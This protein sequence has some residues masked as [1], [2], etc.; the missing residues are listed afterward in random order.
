[1]HLLCV[2]PRGDSVPPGYLKI[3]FNSKVLLG[4]SP[5]LEASASANDGAGGGNSPAIG[6]RIRLE[7][8]VATAIFA[9]AS[10]A[11]AGGRRG[12]GGF[13]TSIWR[14]LGLRA[15]RRSR[16]GVERPVFWAFAAFPQASEKK[17]KKLVFSV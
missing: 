9:D 5:R 2:P 3:H 16:Y 12:L 6:A 10:A 13:G 11:Q 1:M 4:L 15:P 17:P 14:C 8:V 7:L